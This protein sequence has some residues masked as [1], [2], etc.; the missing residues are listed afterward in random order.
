MMSD[1][2]KKYLFVAGAIAIGVKLSILTCIGW[3]IMY[4]RGISIFILMHLL[5]LV[6][7]IIIG[8]VIRTYLSKK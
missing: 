5:T 6:I 8:V 4:S 1:K 2:Y 3:L 7:G